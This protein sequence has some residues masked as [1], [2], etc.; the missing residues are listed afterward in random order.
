M[1]LLEATT[2]RKVP[3]AGYRFP[4]VAVVAW[5]VATTVLGADA[6]RTFKS[7]TA[8]YSVQYPS[9]WRFLTDD[10]EVLDIVNFPRNQQVRGVILPQL[11]ARITV[12]K[13]PTNIRTLETWIEHDILHSVMPHRSEIDASTTPG[14]C[15]RLI[16]VKS[17]WDAGGAPEVY[18]LD[19]AYYCIAE[20]G[21]YRVLL[22]CWS[23]NSNA[24]NL[25]AI[26]IKIARSLTTW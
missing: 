20:A 25:E 15:F 22:R 4:S 3:S 2:V 21:I 16:E 7:V 9:E 8:R 18:S 1:Q 17:Q 11:G 19:T 14:S 13:K 10:S 6:E 24:S 5:L 12:A 26:A 23:D